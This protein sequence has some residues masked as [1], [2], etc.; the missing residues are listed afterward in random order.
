[1][2]SIFECQTE[3]LIEIRDILE[4]CLDWD[5]PDWIRPLVT[6]IRNKN[7]VRTVLEVNSIIPVMHHRV[8]DVSPLFKNWNFYT[9]NPQKPIDREQGYSLWEGRN[10]QKTRDLICHVINEIN[11]IIEIHNNI[12]MIDL[13]EDH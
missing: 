8:V 13:G 2:I 7:S 10:G 5:Y 11:I 4:K 6:W 12:D 3:E 9:G 1:M